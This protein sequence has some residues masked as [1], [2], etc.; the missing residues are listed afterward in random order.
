[1]GSRCPRAERLDNLQEEGP[2][3]VVFFPLFP[4]MS[5]TRDGERI[6]DGCGQ[7]IPPFAKLAAREGG[8]DLCL[9]CQIRESQERTARDA[10]SIG[11]RD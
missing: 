3:P 11:E 10:R 9:A 6:C 2:G 5:M 7:K 4:T 1:M 8:R